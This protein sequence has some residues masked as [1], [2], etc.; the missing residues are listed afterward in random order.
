M[1]SNDADADSMMPEV[2]A[3][4]SNIDFSFHR[5]ESSVTYIIQSSPDLVSGWTDET[6][7]VDDTYGAVGGECSVPVTIP[8]AGK[9]FLRLRVEN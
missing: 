3:S 7:I 2:A 6:V 8:N 9:L 1:T 5:G 4:G